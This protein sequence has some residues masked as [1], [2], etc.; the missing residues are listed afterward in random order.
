MNVFI[1]GLLPPRSMNCL[2]ISFAASGVILFSKY[3]YKK[4]IWL[5]PAF[6]L[7]YGT[8]SSSRLFYTD[9]ISFNQDY[10]ISSLI[11]NDI[12]NYIDVPPYQPVKVYFYGAFT[13]DSVDKPKN[14]DM[15]GSSFLS[16]DAGNSARISAFMNVT[17]IAK[18]IPTP[19]SELKSGLK[20]INS[21]PTWPSKGSVFKVNDVVVVKL[22][23]SPGNC[24]NGFYKNIDPTRCL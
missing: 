5:I 7:L 3:G 1:G 10:R 23:L 8:A 20:Q 9:Y 4:I 18:I 13:I 22:G 14:H 6:S 11:A 15:F 19:Y 2:A 17:G 12:S 24:I 21:A 16:W